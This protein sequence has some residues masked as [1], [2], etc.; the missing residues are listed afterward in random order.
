MF[1]AAGK[2]VIRRNK[3][4][5]ASVCEPEDFCWLWSFGN[6][7]ILMIIKLNRIV[8]CLSL[9]ATSLLNAQSS[10]SSYQSIYGKT[11]KGSNS[12]SAYGGSSRSSGQSYYG[13][14]TSSTYT[15]P[16]Y[17]PPA[18]GTGSNQS[19]VSVPGHTKSSG[20]YVPSYKRSAPNSTQTDNWSTRGNV[21]PYTG[22]YGTRKPTR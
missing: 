17:R 7:F 4:G 22:A 19:S 9:T 2:Y 12:G 14:G 1:S 10:G 13:G 18:Y 21:N 15:P 3:V 6:Q 20:T 16:S 8:L 5:R 11:G